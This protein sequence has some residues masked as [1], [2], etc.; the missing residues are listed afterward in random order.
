MELPDVWGWEAWRA[1][2]GSGWRHR[3]VSQARERC[4]WGVGEGLDVGP[5]NDWRSVSWT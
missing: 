5:S 1:D 2:M 3:W 4:T